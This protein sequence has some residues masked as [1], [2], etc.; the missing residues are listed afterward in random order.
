[1]VEFEEFVGLAQGD[2]CPGACPFQRLGD[3][4]LSLWYWTLRSLASSSRIALAGQKWL[5]YQPTGQRNVGQKS[6]L[7]FIWL[8]SPFCMMLAMA[9]RVADLHLQTLRW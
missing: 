6:V 7:E 8:E 2:R 3:R 1:V 9:G 4:F 5:R